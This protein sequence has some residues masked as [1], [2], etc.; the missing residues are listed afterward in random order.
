MGDAVVPDCTDLRRRGIDCPACGTGGSTGTGPG[1]GSGGG[2]GSGGSS[3]GGAAPGQA[4]QTGDQTAE[5]DN[6][7]DTDTVVIVVIVAVAVVLVSVGYAAG[8]RRG[9]CGE[10]K[11]AQARSRPGIDNPTYEQPT[12]SHPVK[13]DG[14]GFGSAAAA[15]VTADGSAGGSTGY[16]VVAAN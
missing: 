12:P 3:G 13:C 2:S 8:V 1:G 5:S 6:A 10:P 15:A 11:A 16:I 14:F 4:D 7:G 9:Q